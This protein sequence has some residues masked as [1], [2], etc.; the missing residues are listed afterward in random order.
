MGPKP[1]KCTAPCE[2]QIQGNAGRR[3][4]VTSAAVGINHNLLYVLDNNSGRRFLVYTGSQLSVLPM[5]SVLT[6]I[7]GPLLIAA[8][9]S[10]IRNIGTSKVLLRIGTH[11]YEWSLANVSRPILGADFLR[12]NSLLVDFGGNRLIDNPANQPVT[13]NQQTHETVDCLSSPNILHS[14]GQ[15]PQPQNRNTGLSDSSLQQDLL[16]TP[17]HAA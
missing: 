1:K 14:Q 7:R 11:S 9:G 13:N 6:N 16:F 17:T 4:S 5:V 12:K 15:H 8:N 2:F 10:S 3:S